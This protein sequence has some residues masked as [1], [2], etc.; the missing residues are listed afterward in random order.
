MMV[1]WRNHDHA[2]AQGGAVFCGK[3]RQATRPAQNVGERTRTA[4]R[5]MKHNAHG[6]REI[7]REARN[8]VLQRLDPARR[9]A[10]YDQLTA[11]F[12]FSGG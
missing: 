8:Y 11:G 2:L 1:G 12:A 4:G 9:S 5:D 3:T 6:R 10:D 7:R